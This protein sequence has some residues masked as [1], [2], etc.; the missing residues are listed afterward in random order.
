[1]LYP[2][3][4]FIISGVLGTV[5]ALRLMA[6]DA[7]ETPT[8]LTVRGRVVVGISIGIAIAI[9]VILLSGMWWDCDLRAGATTPC[10]VSWG[11]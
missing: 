7:Q 10:L 6:L 4:L 2:V 3:I 11:F 8:K 9:G 5:L 1:M